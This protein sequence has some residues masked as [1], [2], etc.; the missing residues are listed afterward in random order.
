MKT[1]TFLVS[2]FLAV[3]SLA[4]AAIN[5]TYDTGAWDYVASH[6]EIR[7]K[8]ETEQTMVWLPL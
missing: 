6:S 8:W 7:V 1:F 3:S 4:N 2:S 5:V